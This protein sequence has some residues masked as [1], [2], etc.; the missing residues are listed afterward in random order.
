M[1][2]EIKRLGFGAREEGHTRRSAPLRPEPTG[3][4]GAAA[5]RR[6]RCHAR[7]ASP[8]LP[9]TTGTRLHLRPTRKRKID[10]VFSEVY[11]QCQG[12]SL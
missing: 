7:T 11:R 1:F 4:G 5:V 12:L 10:E 8:P 2:A 6:A 3:T 9:P